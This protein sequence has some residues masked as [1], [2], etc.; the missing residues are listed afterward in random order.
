VAALED[1]ISEWLKQPQSSEQTGA[2]ME[3]VYLFDFGSF[4]L[5]LLEDLECILKEVRLS[6]EM[7]V[8]VGI[9]RE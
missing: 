5:G 4:P 7:R 8:G 3:I 9:Q 2:I 6:C 1:H